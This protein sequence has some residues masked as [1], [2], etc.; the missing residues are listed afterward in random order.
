MRDGHRHPPSNWVMKRQW[1]HAF[2]CM[3]METSKKPPR[4][5]VTI[6]RSPFAAPGSSPTSACLA[7][8]SASPFRSFMSRVRG[9]YFVVRQLA[10]FQPRRPSSCFSEGRTSRCTSL[11]FVVIELDSPMPSRKRARPDNHD[12]HDGLPAVGEHAENQ[13]Y[14]HNDASY[15]LYQDRAFII[16]R[17]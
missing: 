2:M 12:D 13:K 9:G 10:H 3:L 4:T 1:S 17:C 14:L 5:T 15:L 7:Q 6:S 11:P 8:A 16:Q